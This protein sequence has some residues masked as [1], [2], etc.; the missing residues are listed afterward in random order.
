MRKLDLGVATSP[1][2]SYYNLCV[3]LALLVGAIVLKAPLF[4][5]DAHFKDFKA[6]V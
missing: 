3:P 2:T 6:I 4:D 1:V 5:K